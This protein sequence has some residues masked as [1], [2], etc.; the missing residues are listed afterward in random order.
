[1]ARPGADAASSSHVKDAG[2]WAGELKER[3]TPG[4]IP[5]TYIAVTPAM[6]GGGDNKVPMAE[7]VCLHKLMSQ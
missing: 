2:R 6:A 1:L 7:F 5:C 4:R 3:N